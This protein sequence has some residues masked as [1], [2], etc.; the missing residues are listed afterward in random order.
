MR[1]AHRAREVLE[2]GS[3]V[4]CVVKLMKPEVAALGI[5]QDAMY[6]EI[7]TQMVAEDWAQ[8]FNKACAKCGLPQRVAFLP[9]SVLKAGGRVAS[10][11]PY[12]EG[13]YVK[14]SD[15]S[16]ALTQ[17]ETAA[18]FSYFTYLRSN[19]RLVVC[20]IQ[21]VGTFYTD[22]Q[23]HTFDGAGFGAGNQGQQG[24]DKFIR[25][26]R[27]TRLCE[28]LGLPRPEPRPRAWMDFWAGARA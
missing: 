13:Q 6:K 28:Q 20:D 23:I 16:T 2:D 27:H 5:S 24:I 11:E 7:Q 17:D 3:E 18:A 10:L 4:R 19:K 9:A 25:S 14:H 26:L 8:Q 12:M 1:R 21:G 15:I 22:P